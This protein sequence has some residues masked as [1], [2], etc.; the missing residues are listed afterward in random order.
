MGANEPALTAAP[1][2]L[3]DIVDATQPALCGGKAAGLGTL[4]RAGF[5]VPAAVCLTTEFYRRAVAASGLA[6]RIADAVG[7][8][9]IRDSTR[10]AALLAALRALVEAMTIPDDLRMTLHERVARLTD[11]AH[12]GLVVRSSAPY[13]DGAAAS[14]AG[15]HASVVVATRDDDRVVAAVR[16]CWASLWTE[17]AWAYRERRGIGHA[18]VTMAVVVQRLVAAERSGVA[19]SADPL[20]GDASAVVIEAGWGTGSALVSGRLTP[21]QS[22]VTV[23]EGM[24]GRIH[25]RAGWHDDVT[26][27]RD[28]RERA[29]GATGASHRLVLTDADAF[30]LARIA[31]AIERAMHAPV[32]VEWASDGRVFWTLQARPITM[33]GVR[34]A[35]A[36]PTVWTRANLKEILPE[37]PSPLALSYL[38]YSLDLMF[39]TYHVA[40]GYVLPPDARLVSV[41]HGRPYLNLT[42]MRHMTEAAGG[43]PSVLT[44]LYGGVSVTPASAPRVRAPRREGPGRLRLAG[45]MLTTFF[46]T[47]Y[48]ARR[49]FRMLRRHGAALRAVPLERLDDRALVRHL[50]RFRARL[51]HPT[52]ARR[53]HEIVSAQSR[54]YMALDH[55]LAAWLPS[56]DT[57]TL[58]K[59]L[60]TG[61]GTLPNV[62]MTYQLMRLGSVALREARVRAFFTAE[63]DEAALGG[64]E[65]ELRGTA[66]RTALDEFLRDFGHRGPYESD[67]MSPRFSEDP[68]PLFR[69]IQLYVRAGQWPEPARH[70]AERRRVRL[71]ATDE[72]RRALGSRYGWFGCAWRRS[73]FAIVCGA[74]QRL[75]AL[76]DECRHVTTMMVAHLRRVALEIGRRAA[77]DGVLSTAQ[78]VFFLTFDELPRVLTTPGSGWRAITHGRREERERHRE[79]EAPDLLAAGRDAERTVDARDDRAASDLGGLGVSPGTVTGRVK[80]FRSVEELRLLSDDTVVV[81]RA[82]EPT[83]SSIFPLVRGMIAEMGGLLSHAAIL[84]R[85]Y[86]VPTVVNV[87]A[88]TR[89][90]RD[91]DRVELDGATGRVRVLARAA[92]QAA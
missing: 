10:A 67:V 87:R 31:K 2:I 5:A 76:R 62:R 15:L 82:I 29:D 79:L 59:R 24:P 41:F 69:L 3:I 12:G 33:V 25:R 17:A 80:V 73:V 65:A 48:W 68:A 16:T 23:D 47:P 84:A 88:A 18:D 92:E 22:R 81:F 89:R 39:R 54:A 72:V 19:F 56:S 35:A 70:A 75:L 27:G 57:D 55:L 86:G 6:S 36:P 14:H 13:E 83:L 63:V 7:S 44:R 49:L 28:G 66:F 90:L 46:R 64:A 42:L 52:S 26:R 11:G 60:M 85:E 30:A 37:L 20:T 91:G 45:E 4:M 50:L 34:P 38:A 71:A 58:V 1:D 61:L 51:L 21:E 43:D 40:E 9:G 53:L 8:A 77:R 74:L 78:D 32:D